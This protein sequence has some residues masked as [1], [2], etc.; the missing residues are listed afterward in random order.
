MLPLTLSEIAVIA[1]GELHGD[2][3]IKI[4]GEAVTDSRL[5][6]PGDLFIAIRGEHHDGH[7]FAAGATLAT[8]PVPAPHVLV[9]DIPAALAELAR[10][11]VKSLP[12]LVIAGITGSSGKTTAKDLAAQLIQRLGPVVSPLGSR[13]NEYGLPL[14][15]LQADEDTRF[16]ILEMGARRQGDIAHLC[17][18]APPRYGV[19]LNV[20]HAHIGEF[21][22][23]DKTAVAKSELV[24]AL[25]AD[26]TAILN[27]DDPRVRAM[28]VCTDARVVSFGMYNPDAA[29]WA[30]GVHLDELGHP[31]FTLITPEGKAEITLGLC[32]AQNVSAALAAAALAREL[33]LGLDDIA[34]G[35]CSA[36]PQS[37]YRMEVTQTGG[38]TF[39]NDAYNANPESVRAALRTL[40]DLS[41]GHRSFAVLGHMAE[42]GDYSLQA[43]EDI[44][45]YAESLGITGMI[46]VGKK[47]APILTR[48]KH[49]YNV[50]DALAALNVLEATLEPGDVVLVKGSR[51]ARLERIVPEEDW[52]RC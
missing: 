22:S 47:A 38:I 10:Y 20:G 28:V 14:T 8:R 12:G 33:G 9:T 18:V 48:M 23:L 16:L 5:A 41:Q 17:S 43:H 15:V 40:R 26:G 21:G 31:G 32:G 25:P 42:L 6:R 2:P 45:E 44:G 27:E 11:T 1:G 13:N 30:T 51:E 19:V 46:T 49:G 29:I 37:R 34:D 36:V 35:L 4:T 7:D 24:Q 3:D 52:W 39:I 50:P